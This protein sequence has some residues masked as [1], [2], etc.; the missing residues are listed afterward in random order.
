MIQQPLFDV[1]KL[2][3]KGDWVPPQSLPVLRGKYKSIGLDVESS[4]KDKF[5]DTTC[6]IAVYTPDGKK[7][8]IPHGHLGGGNLDADLVSRWGQAELRDLQIINL[9]TGFDAE[10][11]KKPLNIDLEEQGCTLRDVAHSAA[12]LNE[13]RYAGFNLDSLGHEYVGRGK[14]KIDI[15]PEDFHKVHSSLVG[16]YAEDDAEL[17][18]AINEAQ[19]PLLEKEDL[20]KVLEL[21]D[22]LIWVNNHMER[23]GAR[24]DRR[25]LEGWVKQSKER[26]GNLILDIWRITGV[27]VNPNSSDDLAKLFRQQ[28][29]S[30]PEVTA[31]GQWTKKYLA[32]IAEKNTVVK[33]ALQARQIDSL[34]SKYL[35][36][37]LK[38]LD[39]DDIM[40]FHLYQLRAGD[41]DFGTV[42]GRYSSA[43][44]NVQQVFKCER[45]I[46]EF[47]DEYII[48]EL[49]IPDDGFDMFSGDASQIEFRLFA[50]YSGSQ[51]LIGEYQRDPMKDF[52]QMVADMLGQ[53]RTKAKGNNFGKLYGMGRKKLARQ[54]GL[55]CVCGCPDKYAWDNTRHDTACP[56]IKAN[57]LADEYD[58]K[59]PEAKR[60][61]NTAMRLAEQRGY[62]RTLLGRRR[63]YPERENLHSALNA[64]IQGSAADV[65]KLKILQLYKERKTIG[66]HKLRMPVHDEEVGDIMRGEQPRKRLQEAFAE[67][68]IDLKVPVLW[69]LEFG[70]NWRSCA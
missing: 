14:R 27:R 36:K 70:P 58:S 32:K 23:S 38:R 17:A 69:D 62:V 46:E 16:P 68:V 50:H 18:F 63:R 4:G 53:S 1:S 9:N 33:M 59:F 29:L 10:L 52:H 39:K 64:V 65:F 56:M 25:K 45:Q 48:R 42:S 47:G 54:L 26:Y 37:Y 67:S 30:M 11:L 2:S 12:L 41:E 8:Y 31:D 66:I 22:E 24:L 19:K 34:K 13:N 57:E 61:M 40:R 35:D 28:G 3:V 55:S 44:V 6:G 7:Y 21:E 60:L 5:K 49:F 51:R 15:P 20:V 43:N